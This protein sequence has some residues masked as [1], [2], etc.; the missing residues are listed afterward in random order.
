MRRR[1]SGGECGG[2][3]RAASAGA[4]P[5]VASAL[6]AGTLA[7][8]A[9]LTA[10][11]RLVLVRAF[12]P[13]DGGEHAVG[14]LARCLAGPFHLL[15]LDEPSSGLD[16]VETERFAEVLTRV[17]Q[18]R[19][20]GILIVEHDMSLVTSICDYVYVLDFGKPVF[21]GTASEVM[22]APIVKA[23]Y[24]GGDELEAELDVLEA[25]TD[26]R[27]ASPTAEEVAR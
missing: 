15:L 6:S 19:G 11:V 4:L 26:T 16:R 1:V 23:A 18:D 17:V 10:F 21:E 12:L 20:V 13:G 3:G 25:T 7:L 2:G 14:E 8:T 22:A 5:N 9:A 24:L 27:P